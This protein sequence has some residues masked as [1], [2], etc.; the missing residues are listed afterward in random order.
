MTP[1]QTYKALA[2]SKCV[3]FLLASSACRTAFIKYMRP[4]NY[5]ADETL[6][7]WIAFEH[8]YLAAMEDDDL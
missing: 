4:L 2:D 8:G 5:G 7:T 3:S 1:T 6:H